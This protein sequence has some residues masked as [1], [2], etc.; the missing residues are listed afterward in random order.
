[1]YYIHLQRHPYGVIRSFDE[2]RLD[3]LLYAF[4]PNLRSNEEQVFTRLQLAELVW[5]IC[6]R[7]ILEFLREVPSQRQL[8]LRFEDI[9]R[10]PEASMQSVC[11]F[12]AI[13]FDNAMLQPYDKRRARMT[14][15]LHKQSRML[16][17][18]KFHHHKKI[19]DS[20]ADSWKREYSS[21]F[22]GDVTWELARQ[23]GYRS[24]HEEQA[25]TKP[26]NSDIIEK[27]VSEEEDLLARMDGMSDEDIERELEKML[28]GN[29]GG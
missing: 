14:E 17:D 25:E 5:L 23:F 3:Q 13:E 2:A 11:Q 16:G 8:A 1:V 28:A 24:I 6:N 19:D 26:Q 27:L 29:S 20:V 7:N 18:L 21:D 22:L 15:G 9:V 12:L 10:Q 4:M